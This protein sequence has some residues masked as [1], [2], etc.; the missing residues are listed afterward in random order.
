MASTYKTVEQSLTSKKYI[1]ERTYLDVQRVKVSAY[2]HMEYE[3]VEK[4][5]KT[6]T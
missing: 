1:T 4:L 5:F 6:R 3:L 2:E